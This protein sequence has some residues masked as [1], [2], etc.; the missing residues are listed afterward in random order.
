[1]LRPPRGAEGAPVVACRG[2]CGDTGALFPVVQ[3][4]F[5]PPLQ[6]PGAG[7]PAQGYPWGTGGH[8]AA[9]SIGPCRYR[10]RGGGTAS[11]G[12]TGAGKGTPPPRPPP[13]QRLPTS[14]SAQ[15]SAAARPPPR[16]SAPT[17]LAL[18]DVIAGAD[19]VMLPPPALCGCPQP[20]IEQGRAGRGG[21]PPSLPPLGPYPNTGNVP[22]GRRDWGRSV[23]WGWAGGEAL[24]G[25]F[26]PSTGVGGDVFGS[27]NPTPPPTGPS[28]VGSPGQVPVRTGEMPTVGAGGPRDTRGQAAGSEGADGPWGWGQG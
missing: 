25:G 24:L 19:D 26:S 4:H 17:P 20:I 6:A 7:R 12:A 5:A 11:P 28:A 22:G 23:G 15:G 13:P 21:L 16:D 18:N 3:A 27:P 2:V 10:R 14:L 9:A 1:M 8:R